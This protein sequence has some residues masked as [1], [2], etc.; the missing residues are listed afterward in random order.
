MHTAAAS[1]VAWL[2][3]AACHDAAC[4]EHMNRMRMLLP[5]GMLPLQCEH[6]VWLNAGAL[7]SSAAATL[8]FMSTTLEDGLLRWLRAAELTCDRAALLVV[9]VRAVAGS[10][11]LD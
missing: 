4:L 8:P 11:D 10:W 5:S 2:C 6:G 3:A 9:Q 7:A 1:Q